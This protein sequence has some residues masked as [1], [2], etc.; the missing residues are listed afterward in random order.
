LP[1]T[2]YKPEYFQGDWAAGNTETVGSVFCAH[3]EGE[4]TN[5]QTIS[6]QRARFIQLFCL[7]D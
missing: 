6:I 7:K 5:H 2:L 1:E 3:T 4:A